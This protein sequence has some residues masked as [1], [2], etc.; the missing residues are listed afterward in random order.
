MASG[1]SMIRINDGV[2]YLPQSAAVLLTADVHNVDIGNSP[3]LYAR[4]LVIGPGITGFNGGEENRLLIVQPTRNSSENVA[5]YD[6]DSDSSVGNRIINAQRVNDE[7]GFWGTARM[8]IYDS[9]DGFWKQVG[10]F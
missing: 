6:N 4:Q 2:L 10:G 7:F 9:G 5:V 1:I 3:V 8:Y